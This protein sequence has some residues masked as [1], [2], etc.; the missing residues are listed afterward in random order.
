MPVLHEL[1]PSLAESLGVATSRSTVPVDAASHVV[2]ILIDGLGWLALNEHHE[3]IPHVLLDG[4]TP[5]FADLPTTTPTGLGAIGTGLPAGEH[6]FVGASFYLP[7]THRIL[8]PLR[9]P[10]HVSP[11]MVQPEATMFE[12][13]AQA[14]VTVTTV[15][16]SAYRESGLTRAVLRGGAYLAADS[17]AHYGEA[18]QAAQEGS[19]RSFTYV[20]WPDLDRAGHKFGVASQ[21]WRMALTVVDAL[22]A[23][24]SS[25]CLP[26]TLIVITADHGMVDVTG[27]DR[28]Q[29]EELAALR[30]VDVLVAGEPRFRHLFVQGDAEH[31][32]KQL[33]G[34]IGHAFDVFTRQEIAESGSFGP[35]DPMVAE[36]V[37]DI[38]CIG[39][40][41]W[42][43]ASRADQRVSGFIGQHGAQT[44]EEREI[45]VVFSRA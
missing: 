39:R 36:R 17:L 25:R 27:D 30:F 40:D 44:A 38:V 12:L 21:Q 19:P 13:M 14:G 8:A 33:K 9:W 18:V 43:L 32:T 45:P 6:G 4:S 26:E 10:D 31:M 24:V 1:T 23:A 16:P 15:G 20:Y 34:E 7:E 42:M 29:L 37:G 22:I 3:L 28:I 2:V 35:I 11:V 41:R 5:W